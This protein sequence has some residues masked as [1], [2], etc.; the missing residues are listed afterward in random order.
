MTGVS[1]LPSSPSPAAMANDVV[2][3]VR[4]LRKSYK[5]IVAVDG[6]SFQV[7]RGEIFGMLGPNGAGK[8][9]TVEILEGL[10]QADGG[11]A[12]IDGVGVKKNRRRVK[13]MIGVQLQ[14]NAFFDNLTL[15]E[16]VQLFATLYG[17]DAS[18][19]DMLARVDL[20]DRAKSRYKH[21]SGGQR[22]RFSIAVAMVNEPVAMFLDEPT[23]G[24]DPQARRRMWKLIDG[25]RS[26]GMAI[27][28][29]THYMEEAEVLC[30]RVAVIDRGAIIAVDA[31]QALIQ[32]LAGRGGQAV[33]R[34]GALTLEDVFLDL[35][36]HQLVE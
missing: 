11:E 21:L 2:I 27:M 18:P 32:Q 9:T 8:T 4:D 14:Q 16:T 6:V 25:L 19:D 30:D 3:D 7:H 28:L 31:P 35:T 22:Q 20:A 26:D 5:D 24:L 34:D 13:G 33:R 1:S 29:T 10:R 15:R 17:S 36:G 12:F 23:T